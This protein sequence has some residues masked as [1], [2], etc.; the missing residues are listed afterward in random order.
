MGVVGVVSDDQIVFVRTPL[1]ILHALVRNL[2]NMHFKK[3]HHLGGLQRA[4]DIARLGT[5]QES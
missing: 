5:F 3:W 1:A 2:D 4:P